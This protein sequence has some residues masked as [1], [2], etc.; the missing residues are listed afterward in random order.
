MISAAVGLHANVLVVP[1]GVITGGVRSEV[2]VTVLDAVL[3]LP[4]A[5]MAVNVLICVTIQFAVVAVASEKVRLVTG[6]QTSVAVAVPSA[7]L[8]SAAVGL[9]ANV[10]VV[11]VGVITGGVRS[12]VQVTVLD[13]VLELPQASMAVNV[14]TCVTIQLAVVAV[15]SEKVRLVTGPQTSVAVAVPSAALISAAVGLHANVLVVPV[16]VITGGV[17]SEV[18]VTVLD[19]V[20]ELP[21]ASMAVNVLTCVTIQLAVVAVASE[22]VRLVTGPQ[23]SVAVAVPSAALISAAVGL[24]ANVLVVPVGVITGGVRSEVQVTVLDAVLELPQASMAVNVLT[25]VTIQLAVVAVASEKVRLVT[26]PQTSVAVA[27]PSAALI[28]AAVGLHANVLVVPVGV[29]TGGVRSEVQ[30]TVLDAVLELPQASMAVNVLT[31]VT[32]QL[33]VVAVASEKVRLVTGPQT[34]VAVAVPSAALISAAVGLHANVLVVPVGV[35]TGGVRS[36]VQVTVLDAVLELPQASMAVNVLT[37]VTIQLAVVAV[38]SEK[39]RLVTGPQTSVAVAVPSA[40]L[41]SAAV[42]LHANVLVVPVGV[43]TGGVRSEVQVTVLDA[44]LELPQASMAV[45]VLTCVTIQLAVVAVASEKVRLVT[46]PQASVAVA[47]PS[48]ALISAA[49]GLHANV[50]VVPV[51]VITGGVRSEVQVTVLDAVLELPQASMAVN[52][53]ACVTIQFAV[54]AVASRK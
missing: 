30:V 21:Q 17:R 48:A 8:I 14:L 2:Q 49:V 29:I 37:C 43:I 28:S 31:C 6:P 18:Q 5:S 4:Q 33:A 32:I 12:E 23:T 10:L 15:A 22:K 25:C 44:V 45:N 11:P 20:L 42:G 24:H 40:A 13:A 46:G 34:S 54:V 35:I 16:G 19:A 3:E 53:L 50:L 39:V 47:V 41:I 51:G 36:E 9:H 38:A 7:A 26:G 52:V 27:V 1:V